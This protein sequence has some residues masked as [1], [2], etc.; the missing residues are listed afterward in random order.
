MSKPRKA[1]SD[2]NLGLLAL[3]VVSWLFVDDIEDIT[4]SIVIIILNASHA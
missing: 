2:I 4:A 3:L 1:S